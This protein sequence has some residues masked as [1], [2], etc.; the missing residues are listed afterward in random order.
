MLFLFAIMA[1]LKV[2]AVP[3]MTGLE[4]QEV[5]FTLSGCREQG[6]KLSFLALLLLVFI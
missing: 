4:V 2:Q 5:K 6:G 1:V 3:S